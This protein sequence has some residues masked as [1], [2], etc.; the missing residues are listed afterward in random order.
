[1]TRIIVRRVDS[2]EVIADFDAPLNEISVPMLKQR[3]FELTHVPSDRQRLLFRGRE[4]VA[5]S[6]TQPL[7][8]LQLEDGCVVHMVLR[9][10]GVPAATRSTPEP[11]SVPPGQGTQQVR[12]EF[13]TFHGIPQPATVADGTTSFSTFWTDM[14]NRMAQLEQELGIQVP[15]QDRNVTPE[16]PDSFLAAA[17]RRLGT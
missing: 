11:S 16:Q 1:M 13:T 4:L 17:I 5:S 12:M 3:V 10:P 7:S 9:Q 6:E 2:P 15:D 8:E 14:I